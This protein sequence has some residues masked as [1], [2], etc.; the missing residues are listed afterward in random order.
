V[1]DATTRE[2]PILFSGPM[3]RA[4]LEGRKQ[5]TRR[6]I[7][8]RH[9]FKL[10]PDKITVERLAE[11]RNAP[12][13]IPVADE[14]DAVAYLRDVCPHGQPGDRLWVRE[15]WY[16]DVSLANE[17]ERLE[18]LYYRADGECC[19]VIPECQCADVGKVRWRPSIHMPRWA[20]RITLE[21]TGVRVERVQDIGDQDALWEGVP[22]GGQ[23]GG[24]LVK[25]FHKI[26]DELNAKRGFGWDVNPWVWVLEFKVLE[27]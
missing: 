27:S 13:S 26:W 14:P 2:R 5:Q 19:D 11:L 24:D 1:S 17:T 15:T 8:H 16:C 6:V 9:A 18:C 20:S 25:T 3:V 10:H 22:V 12:V 23:H 21:L 4:I 7:K